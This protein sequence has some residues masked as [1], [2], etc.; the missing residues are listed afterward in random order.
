MDGSLC[1]ANGNVCSFSKWAPGLQASSF[2]G[3]SQHHLSYYVTAQPIDAVNRDWTELLVH[4]SATASTSKAWV[5]IEGMDALVLSSSTV[6]NTSN[7][8]TLYG[9][10]ELFELFE[11]ACMGIT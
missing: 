7:T 2:L 5:S 3:A 10:E 9:C 4:C 11:M 1:Y 8:R 6:S